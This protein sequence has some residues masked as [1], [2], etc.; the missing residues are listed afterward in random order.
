MTT[1]EYQ[2]AEPDTIY[3]N[4]RESYRVH[5]N[6]RAHLNPTVARETEDELV[7]EIRARVPE[8]ETVARAS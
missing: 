1:D 4:Q 8:I 3:L 7:L 6:K 5:I 2:Q